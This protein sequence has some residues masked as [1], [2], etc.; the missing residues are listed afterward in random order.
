MKRTVSLILTLLMCHIFYAQHISEFTSLS[1]DGQSSDFVLPSTHTFQVLIEN[2]DPLTEGGLMP[3]VLDFAGYVPRTGS[4]KYGYLSINSEARPGAVTILDIEYDDQVGKWFVDNSEAVK[5]EFNLPLEG[6]ASIIGEQ[7]GST[8]ANCSGTVTP[9]NTIITCEEVTNKD[10][11]KDFPLI[12]DS[13]LKVDGD[14]EGYDGYG[15][16]IEIDPGTKTVIDQVGGRAP[17]KQDK[18]WAMGNFKHENAVV[19]SNLRT[20]YQGAD[21]WLYDEAYLFKFVADEKKILS[22]GRLYVFKETSSDGGLWVKIPNETIQERNSTITSCKEVGA[23]SFQ[24]IEDVEIFGDY[25]YFAVKNDGKVY[26][27]KDDVPIPP[28]VPD[29]QVEEAT[30]VS[31]FETYVGDM[32]YEIKA[33]ETV[34]WGLG[35]DNLVFD[36]LGNLWVAQDG[37]DNYIWVVENGH[38]QANPKV[39]IFGRTPGNSEPTGLTFTPDYKYIFMSIQHPKGNDSNQTDVFGRP[40]SFNDDVTLVLARNDFLGKDLTSKDQDIMISQ[41]YHDEASD[42]KWIEVKNISGEDIPVGTYFI[43]LYDSADLVNITSANPKASDTI[44]A[45]MKDEVLLYKNKEMPDFPLDIYIRDEIDPIE[46]AV[47]DFDGDDVILI[48][49]TPGSRKYI[50]RKDIL[51]NT[52]ATQWGKNNSLIRGDNSPELPERNFDPNNWIELDPLQEVNQA[53]KKKNIALGTHV[54]GPA[55]WNGSSWDNDSPPDRTR[56][57]EID[58]IYD[59]GLE[60]FEA[61]DLKIN[62]TGSLNFEEKDFNNN[63]IVHRNLTIDIEGSLIIGD[64]ESLIIKDGDATV[65]GSIEKIEYSSDRNDPNDI[66][67][68]SSPVEGENIESVF[69]DVNLERVFLYDQTKHLL[70]DPNHETYWEVW[71]KASGL[72]QVGKGYAAEG[73]QGT[74]GIHTVQFKGKP[75]FGNIETSTL[76]FH[77][78]DIPD[79]DF[80]LIGN[81]YP[82]AIDLEAFLTTNTVTNKVIDGTVYFWKHDLA[83]IDGTYGDYVTY[84]FVGATGTH[85]NTDV[86]PNIGSAQGFFVRAMKSDKVVFNPSMILAGSNNQFFKAVE[87]KNDIEKNRLWIN[88]IGSDDSFKQ[89]LIGFDRKASKG[90]DLGYDALYLKGSQPID[91]YSFLSDSDVKLAIQGRE[92]F[93][94]D[95][96]ID[97]GFE[98][99]SEGVE[100]QFEIDKIEGVLKDH[101]VLLHDK[102]LEVLHDLNTAPY[103]FN[104]KGTGSFKDRFSLVFNSAVLNVDELQTNQDINMYMNDGKLFIDSPW[105]IQQIKIYDIQGRLLQVYNPNSSNTELNIEPISRINFFMVQVFNEQGETFTRKMIRY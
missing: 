87:Q 88:L 37:G 99:A 100:M 70:N 35:N 66:T 46:S 71:D 22:S 58:G 47:C 86:S 95:M 1:A 23:K 6:L 59:G 48:T 82:A 49:T 28:E 30:T 11:K 89:I 4:S 36:D 80:N 20:V 15:W 72:M 27:F 79:N 77:T 98:V 97:L 74:T 85:E 96:V 104:Y 102:E 5:F 90:M 68:W 10:V 65:T 41:Y 38:T 17:D 83:L 91:F 69:K 76:D 92:P 93:H 8:I 18:L 34:P 103:T 57:T 44:P 31:Q 54:T 9:W 94:E 12:Q 21:D 63:L 50:N 14:P 62:K 78:D 105:F 81:P 55:V 101:D 26:R 51:G 16:A 25:V 53:D 56:N 24:A 40:V 7:V 45:M 19:H 75:N 33:G 3:D 43:D 42:S 73:I 39:K 32:E 2:G 84:N 13:W 52:T 61:F 60:N 67:Y 29:G 64:T